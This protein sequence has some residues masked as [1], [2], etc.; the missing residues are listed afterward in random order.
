MEGEEKEGLF[1]QSKAKISDP[2]SCISC[3]SWLKKEITIKKLTAN[4]PDVDQLDPDVEPFD[5]DVKKAPRARQRAQPQPGA[6][7]KSETI[8]KKSAILAAVSAFAIAF[9]LA[10]A[11][12]RAEDVGLNLGLRTGYAIALGDAIQRGPMSEGIAGAIPLHLDAT[13]AI[14]PTFNAGLYVAY[15]NGDKGSK[16]DAPE[17]VSTR[18]YGL[19]ANMLFPSGWAGVFG[20]LESG[21][22]DTTVSPSAQT[23]TVTVSGWQAGLQGGADWTVAPSFVVGPFASLAMGQYTEWKDEVAGSSYSKDI[24]YTAMHQWL[25]LGLRGSFS[26]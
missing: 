25:T 7:S 16:A 2:L 14:T 19:Q 5:R 4:D 6:P 11:V 17:S 18:A 24:R 1:R 8:M 10:P 22:V 13:F 3:L 26:L 20:G 9:S 23:A 21:N 12:A 15:G